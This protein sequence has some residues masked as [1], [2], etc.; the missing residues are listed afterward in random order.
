MLLNE[1]NTLPGQ[2]TTSVYGVLW[3]HDGVAYPAL[4]TEICELAIAR[5]ERERAL[6]F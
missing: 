1:I 2:T 3:E 4:L 6:L 5:F